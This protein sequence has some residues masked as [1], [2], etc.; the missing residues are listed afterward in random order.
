MARRGA[1]NAEHGPRR[2]PPYKISSPDLAA[3]IT[4]PE[5]AP[6]MEL[7]DD[8]WRVPLQV[9]DEN[10]RMVPVIPPR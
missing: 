9:V 1:R 8:I 7:G 3:D 5:L 2:G 6:T 4:A 10:V